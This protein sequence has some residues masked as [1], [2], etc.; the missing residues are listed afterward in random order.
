[1]DETNFRSDQVS[2]NQ[3][4][5]QFNTFLLHSIWFGGGGGGAPL[6]KAIPTCM[7]AVLGQP[8]GIKQHICMHT[9]LC[10]IQPMYT[11]QYV[12]FFFFKSRFFTLF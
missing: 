4:L 9:R 6:K 1:M 5:L 12:E 10:S 7:R 8:M 11:L 2:I 3:P